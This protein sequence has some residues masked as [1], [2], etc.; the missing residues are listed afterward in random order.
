MTTGDQFS[1]GAAATSADQIGRVFV[2]LAQD[3]RKCLWDRFRGVCSA[4]KGNSWLESK[5]K[6]L[7]MVPPRGGLYSKP[8]GQ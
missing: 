3:V 5:S 8:A 7:R 2:A 1:D 4:Q 6:M